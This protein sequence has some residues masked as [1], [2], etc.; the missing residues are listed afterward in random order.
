MAKYCTSK[1]VPCP[2]GDRCP[3]HRGI[4]IALDRAA[5]ELDFDSFAQ[6]KSDLAEKQGTIGFKRKASGETTVTVTTPVVSRRVTKQ[7][8]TRSIEYKLTKPHK[9]V[10]KLGKLSNADLVD[11]NHKIIFNQYDKEEIAQR[12]AETY[13]PDVKASFGFTE[14][15]E[16]H[17]VESIS[18]PEDFKNK[19]VSKHIVESLIANSREDLYKFA[20]KDDVLSHEELESLDFQP[21]PFYWAGQTHPVTGY[22]YPSVEALEKRINSRSRTDRHQFHYGSQ[23]Y[24]ARNAKE[25]PYIRTG[26]MNPPFTM[27]DFKQRSEATPEQRERYYAYTGEHQAAWDARKKEIGFW[28]FNRESITLNG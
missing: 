2:A 18:M 7:R 4:M 22:T 26:M 21:N 11:K 24:T 28:N 14:Y 3:E 16:I 23:L 25:Y 20:I 10:I 19:G 8:G 27:I 1:V 17:T 9:D 13:G 6:L 15:G 12:I 5:K